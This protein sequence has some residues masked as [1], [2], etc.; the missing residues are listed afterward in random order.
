MQEATPARFAD[1]L[2]GRSAEREEQET[3][4]CHIL[5]DD[6]WTADRHMG[7]RFTMGELAKRRA[8]GG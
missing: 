7:W 6:D 2:A 1:S 3:F 4:S 5:Q 8:R